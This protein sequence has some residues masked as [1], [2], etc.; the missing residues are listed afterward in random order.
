MMHLNKKFHDP[1]EA[2]V[3]EGLRSRGYCVQ[4][5]TYHEVFPDEVVRRLQGIFTPTALY[6]RGRA[7]RVAVHAKRDLV[8]EWEAKT[9]VSK[10]YH[11]MCLEAVPL[12]HH[13]LKCRLGVR[14]LYVYQDPGELYAKGF[15]VHRMPPVRDVWLPDRWIDFAREYFLGVLSEFFPGVP[16]KD[17]CKTYGTGDPY[18]VIDHS[19]VLRLPSWETL[20]DEFDEEQSSLSRPG[21][22]TLCP[23]PAP[24]P[25]S[26]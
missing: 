16:L 14:C 5:A 6:V 19:E 18:V 11:D 9:H 12:A 24:P 8:F 1:F 20:V 10:K 13:V 21:V 2:A 25:A 7:D 26:C 15:W 22:S 4:G 17:K 3:A 23:T